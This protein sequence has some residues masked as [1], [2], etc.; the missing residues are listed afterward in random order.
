MFV[1]NCWFH[2]WFRSAVTQWPGISTGSVCPRSPNLS[3]WKPIW[4]LYGIHQNP[5]Q[6]AWDPCNLMLIHMSPKEVFGHAQKCVQAPCGTMLIGTDGRRLGRSLGG[7]CMASSCA[8]TDASTPGELQLYV[9]Y[10]HYR[11][12]HGAWDEPPS[13]SSPGQEMNCDEIHVHFY[14]CHF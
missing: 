2:D 14:R 12:E 5:G 1:Y 10:Q 8:L 13:F 11:N 6:S 4:G 7:C 3:P 9:S